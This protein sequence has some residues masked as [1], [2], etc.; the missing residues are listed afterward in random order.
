MIFDFRMLENIEANKFYSRRDTGNRDRR[1]YP[2]SLSI[3]VGAAGKT[4]AQTEEYA[5]AALE[6]SLGRGGDQA[7]VKRFQ[8]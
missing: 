4:P 5:T 2:A 1:G 8:L 3:G 7:V 6:L